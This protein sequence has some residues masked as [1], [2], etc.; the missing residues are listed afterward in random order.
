VFVLTSVLQ[1]K[2]KE[3]EK[4]GEAELGKTKMYAQRKRDKTK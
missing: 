4:R 3:R 1:K 2:K